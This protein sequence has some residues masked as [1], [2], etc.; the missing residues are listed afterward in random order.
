MNLIPTRRGADGALRLG[1]GGPSVALPPGRADGAGDLVFGIRPEDVEVAMGDATP[2]NRVDIP[3]I[4]DVVEPLGADTFVFTTASG[5][6][7]A[8]RVRPEVRPV[9]GETLKLRLNLD[10]MHL[11]DS[12]SGRAVGAPRPHA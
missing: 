8:A 11:F 9:P 7:V 2:P 4:V 5:H 3:A 6:P 12:A 10:R 1:E